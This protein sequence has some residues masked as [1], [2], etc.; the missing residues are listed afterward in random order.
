MYFVLYSLFGI[1]ALMSTTRDKENYA[2]DKFMA[3]SFWTSGGKA[4]LMD[5]LLDQ[6]DSGRDADNNFKPTV[7]TEVA[8]K[9]NKTRIHGAPKTEKNCKAQFEE[10]RLILIFI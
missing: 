4:N 8:N 5:F 7:W 9:L 10:V 1:M 3:H 6:L 2:P